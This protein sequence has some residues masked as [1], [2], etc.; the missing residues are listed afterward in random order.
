MVAL[1]TTA[2]FTAVGDGAT[3]VKLCQAARC[4]IGDEARIS[5]SADEEKPAT[6]YFQSS[7]VAWAIFL[8]RPGNGT[9]PIGE[10]ERIG[11][12]AEHISGSHE[13]RFYGRRASGNERDRKRRIEKGRRA[14][15]EDKGYA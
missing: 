5:K 6:E 9:A 15:N 7:T 8:R 14:R 10:G 13:I 12:F 4:C 2:I 1:C 11:R 3:G